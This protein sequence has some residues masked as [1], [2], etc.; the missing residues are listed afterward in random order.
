[1]PYL[2]MLAVAQQAVGG[3]PTQ[4]LLRI[5]KEAFH[6][7]EDEWMTFVSDGAYRDQKTIDRIKQRCP[8]IFAR[9]SPTNVDQAYNMGDTARA[10]TVLRYI[11]RADGVV[12]EAQEFLVRFA[13]ESV[14]EDLTKFVDLVIGSG[15]TS[16]SH[17]VVFA[18]M[19][20]DSFSSVSISPER[21]I[22][23]YTV[24]PVMNRRYFGKGLQLKFEKNHSLSGRDIVTGLFQ[25]M[26]FIED[27]FN[28]IIPK[29]GF[30]FKRLSQFRD[31]AEI[32]LDQWVQT[33]GAGSIQQVV[34][35]WQNG[36]ASEVSSFFGG[37]TKRPPKEPSDMNEWKVFLGEA[38]LWLGEIWE[39][40]IGKAH[41][42]LENQLFALLKGYLGPTLVEQH[43]EPIWVQPQHLSVYFPE[44][45][46][47]V[48]FM[49]E[50][51]YRPSK[52]F[53]GNS[54]FAAIKLRDKRKKQHCTSNNIELIYVR[55]DEDVCTRASEIAEYTKQKLEELRIARQATTKMPSI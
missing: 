22:Q 47:A 31:W 1:M 21:L 54:G 2:E 53:G 5:L 49:G 18:V 3:E 40:E 36:T 24:H 45:S 38:A 39:E 52:F 19:G 33:T 17:S 11:L 29:E 27:I 8:P 30:D 34:S 12:D 20:H 23:L 44:A 14:G 9:I 41:W 35:I 43:A 46:I 6:L 7:S 32:R 28:T 55:Y 4:E 16:V 15:I 13:N 10:Q 42:I 50:Q 26:P 48:D 37:T 25:K 51:H